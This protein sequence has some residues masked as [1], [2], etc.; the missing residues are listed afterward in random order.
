MSLTGAQ[1]AG[2][3]KMNWG[4]SDKLQAGLL[5]QKLEEELPGPARLQALPPCDPDTL[6]SND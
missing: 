3:T 2:D 1:Q 4:E 5:L 6:E